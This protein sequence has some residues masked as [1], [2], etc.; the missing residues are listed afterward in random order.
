M[1]FDAYRKLQRV[2]TVERLKVSFVDYGAGPPLLLIH[3]I[4]VWGF[5][6]SG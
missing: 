5:L 1:E 6:Y 3:G 2:T 4:P